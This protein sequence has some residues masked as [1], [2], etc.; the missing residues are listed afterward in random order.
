MVF[1]PL[2][3]FADVI[4]FLGS[5]LSMGLS[6]FS[7]I[8]SLTLSFTTIAI[9]WLVYRPIVGVGLIL[10]GLVILGA[11]KYLADQKKKAIPNT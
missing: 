7:G 9:A 11:V 1:K 8:I 5:I 3:V 10:A 4:P 2:V 6:A